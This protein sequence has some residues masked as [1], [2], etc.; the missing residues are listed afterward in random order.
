MKKIIEKDYF[1]IEEDSMEDVGYDDMIVMPYDGII[2]F[3]FTKKDKKLC[4][5][6]FK[7]KG[8]FFHDVNDAANYFNVLYP[9]L[10]EAEDIRKEVPEICDIA[11]RNGKYLVLS[12]KNSDKKET[13]ESWM[14]SYSEILE[15]MKTNNVVSE[16]NI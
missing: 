12:Y 15:E 7:K 4:R 5:T 9:I 2:T 8:N 13:P 11:E 3:C 14:K 6:Y 16:G 10:V 1:I